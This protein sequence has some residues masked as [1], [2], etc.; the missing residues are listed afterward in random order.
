M[1]ASLHFQTPAAAA[2]LVSTRGGTA[3]DPT[4]SPISHETATAMASQQHQQQQLMMVAP[5]PPIRRTK[6]TGAGGTLTTSQWTCQICEKTFA[7]NSNYKNHIRT[8]SNER[9]FVCEICAIGSVAR[10]EP[11]WLAA[12]LSG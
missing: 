12:W 2:G 8:H 3:P 7:Q 9:P 11:L 10:F 1:H 4:P 5:P 6:T